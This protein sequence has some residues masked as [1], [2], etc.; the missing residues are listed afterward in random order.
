MKAGW[1]SPAALAAS[2]LV[3]AVLAV[4]ASAASPSFG[5]PLAPDI[6]P[7]PPP[8]LVAEVVSV[9]TTW[10]GGGNPC[11]GG[12]GHLETTLS[13]NA[14]GGTPPYHFEWDF[15]DSSPPSVD[16]RATHAY[17]WNQ[18]AYTATLTVTDSTGARAATEA[19]VP[20]PVFA[21]A[22]VVIPP[23]Y[24]LPLA[25]PPLAIPTAIM[26]LGVGIAMVVL[27][28]RRGKDR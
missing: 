6:V 18:S 3:V 4:G 10:T 9:Q 13:G 14:S 12:F 7:I 23:P 15:G 17:A 20:E 27:S 24:S 26:A 16:Q 2:A 21:C 25:I 1:C 28:I 19:I 8:G 5:A 11:T 22:P